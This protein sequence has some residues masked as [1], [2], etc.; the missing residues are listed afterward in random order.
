MRERKEREEEGEE[1]R[2]RER[3]T[4]ERENIDVREKHQLVASHTCLAALMLQPT[5]PPSGTDNFFVVFF[6]Y[7]SQMK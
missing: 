2:E 4:D 1:G 7:V 3:N 5:E 6:I